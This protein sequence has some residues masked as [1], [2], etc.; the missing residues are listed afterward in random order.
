MGMPGLLLR[1]GGRPVLAVLWLLAASAPGVQAAEPTAESVAP[2]FAIHRFDVDG[3]TLLKPAEIDAAISGYTGSGRDFSDI[4]RALEVL[5]E[6]YR[7]RGYGVVQVLLPEQDITK[8]VVRLRVI[9]PK[10][11]KI[12]VEGNQFYDEANVRRSLP[13]LTAGTTPNSRTI[14]QNLQLLTENPSKQTTLLLKAGA[15][16]REVD[17]AIK[18]ADERPYKF[19]FTA[20]NSGSVE[21]GRFR[22]GIAVQHSNLFNR[23]HVGTFQYVTSPENPNKVTIFGAGYRVPLYALNSSIDVFGGYS[24]VSSG[25]LA[26][27][28]NVSGSGTILGARYNFHLPRLGEYE[29]RVAAGL[30]YRAFKN[31]VTLIGVAGGLVPDI[32]IHPVSVTYN[33]LWRLSSSEIGINASYSRNLFHGGNDGADSDFKAS[34]AGSTADYRI[35]RLGANYTRVL[36]QEWQFR[37]VLTGQYSDDALVSGEQ[38]G[39]GGPD[40]VRGFSVRE[41]ANDKGYSAQIELYTPDLGTRFKWKDVKLRLLGFYDVGATGRNSLQLGDLSKGAGGASVGMGARF[42]YGKHMTLRIDW[43]NVI[44]SAGNQAKDDQMVNA[45]LAIQF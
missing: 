22:T 10:I 4:Q 40:S 44:D 12:T 26:G 33:G 31:N 43:A 8:G 32:T 34:R 17:A 15:S 45:T 1:H 25:T 28:F 41:V 30:D 21:T 5:E 7:N 18:V 35:W 27:L 37:A 2:R 6:V 16:D 39:Y 38:F 23:D 29:Q 20:D 42:G 13:A 14:A 36:P 11:A 9:E 19:V 3:N 24:D